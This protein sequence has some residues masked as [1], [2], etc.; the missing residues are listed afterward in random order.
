MCS[1]LVAAITLGLGA[2]SRPCQFGGNVRRSYLDGLPVGE[3]V[4]DGVQ[5]IF[6]FYVVG[7]GG[8]LV[9][10][11]EPAGAKHLVTSCLY[12]GRS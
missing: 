8:D 2:T 5:D 6:V 4:E 11:P 10:K 3:R 12:G 7:G 9:D 1:S